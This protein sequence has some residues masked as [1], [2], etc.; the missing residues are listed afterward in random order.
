MATECRNLQGEEFG[1]SQHRQWGRMGLGPGHY[2][3]QV[4][5]L[6]PLCFSIEVQRQVCGKES[7]KIEAKQKVK[8]HMGC[9]VIYFLKIK[10]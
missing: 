3:E 1:F 10:Q 5:C 9:K 6:E 4:I 8:E 7:G 2:S